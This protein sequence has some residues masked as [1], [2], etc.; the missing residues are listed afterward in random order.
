[1]TV[2]ET[3][4]SVVVTDMARATAFYGAAFDAAT[5]FPS[6]RWTSLRVAGVRIG[7][8]HDPAHIPGRIG[9]HFVVTDLAAT[10]RAVDAAGGRVVT[11]GREVAPGVV[12]AD[13]A[14]SEGNELSLRQ[15]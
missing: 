11:P 13:V 12:V 8:F 6:P 2:T 10:C 5:M 14:D 7:L 9:L 4:F 15:A 1:M 3:F